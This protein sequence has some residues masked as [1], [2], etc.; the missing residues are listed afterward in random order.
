MNPSGGPPGKSPRIKSLYRQDSVR[1]RPA[2]RQATYAVPASGN[3]NSILPQGLLNAGLSVLRDISPDIDN[4]RRFFRGANSTAESSV[5]SNLPKSSPD[6]K[7]QRLEGSY[8]KDDSKASSSYHERRRNA[9]A[10]TAAHNG[11]FRCL[12]TNQPF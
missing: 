1:P 4:V 11:I 12:I 6:Q 5:V 7:R 8:N 3:I 9:E 2:S 10:D